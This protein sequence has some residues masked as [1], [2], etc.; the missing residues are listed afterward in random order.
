MRDDC[1]RNTDCVREEKIS[2]HKDEHVQ[3]TV[4]FE[5]PL[6]FLIFYWIS[7]FIFFFW[8]KQIT[9]FFY[10]PLNFPKILGKIS[11]DFWLN[12]FNF[13]CIVKSIVQDISH[14]YIK[15]FFGFW[16]HFSYILFYFLKIINI[17][18]Q[19]LVKP[20]QGSINFVT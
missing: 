9:I 18:T 4:R 11:W 1:K 16:F 5:T 13:F 10:L 20:F 12:I 17:W 3:F 15:I 8:F 19:F 6:F 7:N 2:E 14:K